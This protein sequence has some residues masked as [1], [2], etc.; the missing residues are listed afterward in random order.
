MHLPVDGSA[1][2]V[3]E[4]GGETCAYL[5]LKGSYKQFASA[6]AALGEYIQNNGLEVI[7]P[8]REVYIRGPLFGFMTFIPTMITD[9]YFTLKPV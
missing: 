3:T 4:I 7:A 9:I 6:Y 8:P 2:G 1:G 5:R